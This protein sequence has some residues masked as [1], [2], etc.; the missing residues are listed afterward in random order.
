MNKTPHLHPK[1][2][3]PCTSI[4]PPPKPHPCKR[5][6]LQAPLHAALNPYHLSP[7]LPLTTPSS[8]SD[9]LTPLT[10]PS[11]PSL[12]PRYPLTTPSLSPHYALLPVVPPLRISNPT[13]TSVMRVWRVTLQVHRP[14]DPAPRAKQK[15][16]PTP[17]PSVNGT[18]QKEIPG[19]F[20]CLA[21]FTQHHISEIDSRPGTFSSIPPCVKFHVVKKIHHLPLPLV[22]V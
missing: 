20:L 8:P 9:P 10:T 21:S 6:R 3:Q 22:D 14:M 19:S 2:V 17:A 7:S 1:Q 18:S 12:P 16:F 13:V 5:Y 15:T 4:T 11:S